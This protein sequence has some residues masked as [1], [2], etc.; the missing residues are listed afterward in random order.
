MV[1]DTMGHF[2]RP[3]LGTSDKP[4]SACR[5]IQIGGTYRH[6]GPGNVVE[7][8]KVINVGPDAMG[9]PHVRYEVEVAQ[10]RVRQTRFAAV[11]T[12]NLE[13]FNDYFAEFVRA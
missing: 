6:Q 10:S 2:F 11:R 1:A 12:L 13:T 7:T 3:I 4:A 8:A 5:Q 9:I